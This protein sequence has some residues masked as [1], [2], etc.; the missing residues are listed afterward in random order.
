MP[1]FNRYGAES[2]EVIE[3]CPLDRPL[4]PVAEGLDVT[5]AEFAWHVTH[6]GALS[7]DDILDRRTRLGLVKADRE[8]ALPAAEEAL[9]LA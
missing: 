5:R 8:A 6:E 4:A 9:R 1:L 2:F 7:V 3:S